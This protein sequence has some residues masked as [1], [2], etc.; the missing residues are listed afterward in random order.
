VTTTLKAAAQ[1]EGNEDSNIATGVYTI[2]AAPPAFSPPA[3]SYSGAQQVTISTETSGA[4][5]YYTTDGTEPTVASILYNGAITVSESLII[6]AIAIKT[7]LANSDVAPAA[8]TISQIPAVSAVTF[9]PAGGSF[10]GGGQTIALS[11][12]TAG[13]AIRYTLNGT[14]PSSVS[15]ALYSAPITLSASV[16]IKAIAYKSGMLDSAVASAIYRFVPKVNNVRF[17]T[18]TKILLWD[19]VSVPGSA[20]VKYYVNGTASAFGMSKPIEDNQGTTETSLSVAGLIP[21]EYAGVPFKMSINV[22]A[23]AVKP[24]G[25]EVRG[26]KSDQCEFTIIK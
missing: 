5:I 16:T 15:G 18:P 4:S 25:G 21:D 23:S 1:K 10:I 12:A 8:Y 9:D 13:A 14:N 17:D 3:G 19:A 2:K 24:G 11:C 6:K 26:E 7:G 22:T 20:A